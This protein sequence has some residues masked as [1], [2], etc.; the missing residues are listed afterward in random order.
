M[1]VSGIEARNSISITDRVHVSRGQ[2]PMT[3]EQYYD[4]LMDAAIYKDNPT[5]TTHHKSKY[6]KPS[7][8]KANMAQLGLED[9]YDGYESVSSKGGDDEFLKAYQTTSEHDKGKKT[10]YPSKNHNDRNKHLDSKQQTRVRQALDIW[11]RLPQSSRDIILRRDKRFA[12]MHGIEKTKEQ[13]IP[14][15]GEEQDTEDDHHEEENDST[16]FLANLAGRDQIKPYDVRNIMATK[17]RFRD[18][19][20]KGKTTYAVNAHVTYRI[21]NNANRRSRQQLLI[22]QGCNGS[23]AG[24]NVKWIDEK[25]DL[26]TA[27]ISGIGGHEI[28]D[29][30]IGTVAGVLQTVHH[31]PIVGIFHQYA[32][33]GKGKTIHSVGQ[34]ES[35]KNKVYDQSKRI[36][37]LQQID[38]LE[39]YAIPLNVRS[40]LCYLDM[41][42]PSDQEWDTL[43]HVVMTSDYPWDPTILD[44]EYGDK[45]LED[46][47]EDLPQYDDPNFDQ[48]GQYKHG[49]FWNTSLM[50]MLLGMDMKIQKTSYHAMTF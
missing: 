9:P 11:A 27:N 47:F 22:V 21:S 31:G 46:E 20:K 29:L 28:T 4:A 5:V 43:P 42:P 38:T 8:R 30:K 15:E 40:G 32:Y 45:D 48:F 24:D 44:C 39:G 6:L 2:S 1:A 49:I 33:H 19:K 23:M 13:D 10:Y 17:N 18:K 35:Y 41:H 50:E 7:I 14:E 16:S 3:F 25:V 37:G 12:N 34:F 26:R 36:G